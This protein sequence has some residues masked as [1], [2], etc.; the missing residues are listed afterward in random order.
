MPE[1]LRAAVDE[2]DDMARLE[3]W[4]VLVSIGSAGEI[5]EALTGGAR[6]G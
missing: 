6:R 5:A 4:G 3:A 2:T 1:V